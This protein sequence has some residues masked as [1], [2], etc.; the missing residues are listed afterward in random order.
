[1]ERRRDFFLGKTAREQLSDAEF[2]G[3]FRLISDVHQVLG[4]DL[5]KVSFLIVVSP[6]FRVKLFG[7]LRGAA[8]RIRATH[9]YGSRKGRIEAI[10]TFAEGVQLLA[11]AGMPLASIREFVDCLTHDCTCDG[12]DLI[13]GERFDRI[14]AEQVMKS[15]A[16]LAD[17]GAVAEGLDQMSGDS[18]DG[19]ARQF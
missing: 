8:W 19:S 2:L 7:A 18:N 9:S 13:N 16:C 4:D 14:A 5:A 10:Q 12:C 15:P 17:I 6:A 11:A 1:M 3:G